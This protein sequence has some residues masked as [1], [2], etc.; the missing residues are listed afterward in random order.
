[1][2]LWCQVAFLH[3]TA[4][5]CK[6]Y[7]AFRAKHFEQIGYD[8]EPRHGTREL[9]ERE[10]S[11][12]SIRVSRRD[13]RMPDRKVREVR[14][15]EMPPKLRKAYDTAER[16]FVLEYEDEEHAR[17]MFSTTRWI[18]M[19]RMCGGH[20]DGELVW[21][22]KIRELVSLLRGE[23]AREQ[24]VVWFCFNEEIA[25]CAT[26]LE[27]VGVPARV[28]HGDVPQAKRRK[29][30]DAFERGEFCVFLLQQKV[31]EFGMDL[32]AADTAI[33]YSRHP[34]LQTNQQSE[35]RIVH[36]SKGDRPLLYVDL[37]AKDSVDEDVS[38]MVSAKRVRSQRVMDGGIWERMQ[39]RTRRKQ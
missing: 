9:I 34:A 33:V 22:G 36:M 30:R 24:V 27:Q 29:D 6:T 4:F 26:A 39:A 19:R 18:W 32:S 31:A 14:T 21:D 35:D 23:L 15:L 11:R 8:W 38:E 25:A 13:A 7:W 17:T 28:M 12:V 10:L 16:D 37:V 20:L 5:G 3:G 1:M 2:D